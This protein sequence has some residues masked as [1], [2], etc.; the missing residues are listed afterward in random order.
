MVGMKQEM[1]PPG[2]YGPITWGREYIPK[3]IKGNHEIP[4]DLQRAV[5]NIWTSL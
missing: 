1:P 2:G 3:N 4:F 5:I